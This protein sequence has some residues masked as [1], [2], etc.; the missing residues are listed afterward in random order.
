SLQEEQRKR[1]SSETALQQI[2]DL[3]PTSENK[4][5]EQEPHTL[6]EEE[7]LQDS[8]KQQVRTTKKRGKKVQQSL[9][10]F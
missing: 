6:P 10:D 8:Q 3:K 2:Q 7:P 4:P 9:F 1:R 5:I